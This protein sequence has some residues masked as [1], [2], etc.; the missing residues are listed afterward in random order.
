M[1]SLPSDAYDSSVGASSKQTIYET[2][3][4]APPVVPNS[5]SMD[6][7]FISIEVIKLTTRNFLFWRTH[8]VPFLRGQNLLGFVDGLIPCPPAYV[9]NLILLSRPDTVGGW[10]VVRNYK[11]D[12]LVGAIFKCFAHNAI[13]VKCQVIIRGINWTLTKGE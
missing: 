9:V 2:A 7:Q 1:V 12:M 13:K 10:I 11:G 4:P 3:I 5:L 8:L 6:H